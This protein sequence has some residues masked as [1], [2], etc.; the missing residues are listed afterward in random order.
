[1]CGSSLAISIGSIWINGI[2][3]RLFSVP[4]C[5]ENS[6]GPEHAA[7]ERHTELAPKIRDHPVP[8][9]YLPL[10]HTWCFRSYFSFIFFVH[11]FPY[12]FM[13]VS[14]M[15]RITNTQENAGP[16]KGE[17]GL[18]ENRRPSATFDSPGGWEPPPHCNS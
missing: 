1:M 13:N 12:F 5:C 3:G 2:P 8:F 9:Q 15:T 16:P 6:P 10:F 7:H 14:Q 17:L 4:T 11:I 18:S